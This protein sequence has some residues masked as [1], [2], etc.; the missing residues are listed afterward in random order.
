[1]K[2]KKNIKTKLCWTIAIFTLLVIGL[3]ST[4]T[5]KFR[6]DWI[7]GIQDKFLSQREK[8]NLDVLN[9]TED[10]LY[11]VSLQDIINNKESVKYN[12]S[13][14]LVNKEHKI[15]TESTF[16]LTNFRETS[17]LL[18]RNLIDDLEK[19]LN[20]AKEETD[21]K[22][23]I[24]STYRTKEEQEKLYEENP[25]IA[26]PV[27]TSEHQTGLALD[28]YVYQKA[29]REFID[30]K[31]GKWVHDNSWRYGFIIRYP[32][33]KKHITGIR[34]EPWHIRYVGE[35][36]AETMYKNKL[37]FEQYLQSLETDVFYK[38]NGYIISRQSANNEKFKIPFKA[39][40]ITLS[41]DN[42]GYYIITGKLN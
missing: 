20:D 9:Y 21:Q 12:H 7:F 23:L 33:L 42:T 40:N 15:N 1:M 26:A 2:I 13:L 17:F 36:H 32:F 22:I 30:T 28:L 38:V 37:T 34:Y 35:P 14:Y 5:I 8:I 6:S 25:R 41:P 29:Q 18:E 19:L 11:T 27:N 4:Y 31:A 24:M 3:F 39:K 10:E 16:E